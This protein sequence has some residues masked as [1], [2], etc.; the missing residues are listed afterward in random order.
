MLFCDA[1]VHL[2][3]TVI[4][5]SWS[6]SESLAW[7][8]MHLALLL[9]FQEEN[10]SE[11]VH[12]Q[13]LFRWVWS[14]CAP[15][16]AEL[17]CLFCEIKQNWALHWHHALCLTHFYVHALQKHVIVWENHFGLPLTLLQWLPHW[18]FFW[19]Y[20][21]KNRGVPPGLKSIWNSVKNT[22]PPTNRQTKTNKI[23]KSIKRPQTTANP[24]ITP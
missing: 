9:M 16:L 1:E 6:T 17:I 23:Y 15:L 13:G 4:L 24:T 5:N 10:M 3:C 11:S 20:I 22:Q 8:G 19:G 21:S 18:W 7:H 14:T 2:K 12:I